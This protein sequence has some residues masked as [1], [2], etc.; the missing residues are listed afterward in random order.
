MTAVLAFARHAEPR[1]LSDVEVAKIIRRELKAAFPAVKF[2]VRSTSSV[3]VRWMDGPSVAAVDAIVG[4]FQGKDFDG[5]QDLETSRGAF[6]YEGELVK[7][8]C[9]VFTTRLMSPRFV[10]RVIAAVA[11]YWNLEPVSAAPASTFDGSSHVVATTAQDQAAMSRAGAYWNEL[12]HRAAADRRRV[13][14]GNV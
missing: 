1:Y 12:V 7:S 14:F 13:E 6:R 10:E 9:Y 4:R 2:S 11:A 5:M 8:Y 3:N